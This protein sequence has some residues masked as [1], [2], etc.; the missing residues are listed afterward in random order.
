M[1]AERIF[2]SML[3][4]YP[5]AFR[6][7][8]G[9]EMRRAFREELQ[10]AR[11]ARQWGEVAGIW[12]RSCQDI[13][14]T[15]IE[16][17][18]HMLQQDLRYAWRT[19]ATRPGFAAISVLSLALGIGANIAVYSLVDS[20]L[21]R[22]LPVEAPEALFLLTDPSVTGGGT[23]MEAGDRSRLTY[24]EFQALQGEKRVFA[25]IMASQTGLE[26]LSG[27]LG[28]GEAEDLRVRL[29]SEDYFGTLGVEA[30]AGRTYQ[31]SDGPRAPLAVI[32]YDFWQRRLGGRSEAV[33]Q[34]LSLRQSSYTIVGVMPRGFFGETVGQRPDVWLPLGLQ[35]AIIPGK[36]LLHDNPADLQKVMWLHVF[37][38]LQER[39]TRKEAQAAAN[40]VFQRNL[41]SFYAGAPNEE[42]RRNF[43]NQRIVV[44][45]ASLGVSSLREN[46]EEPLLLLLGAAGLVLAIACANLGNLM[47]TR[48]AGRAREFS[49]R[50]ALGAGS[51][52]LTRQLV[53]E[54]MLLA[55]VS[56]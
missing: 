35:P 10:A 38:R 19:L 39:V 6:R 52:N 4:C 32:S 56:Y 27:R 1:W 21:L 28:Q 42:M 43:L 51:S 44:R 11:A 26:T 3:W 15:A 53:T 55:P 25:R 7:E 36:D 54:C 45:P 18:L 46:F 48:V 30:V 31:A 23:G 5:A 34:T 13:F 8:Y 24:E 29:V 37:A 16:E 50:L 22:S 33:G 20:L 49:V 12:W 9:E 47:M 14:T 40:V 2:A 17:H 41:Q